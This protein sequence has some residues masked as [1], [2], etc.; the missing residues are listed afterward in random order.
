MGCHP[1]KAKA[2]AQLAALYAQ[3]PK[4]ALTM[5]IREQRAAA[6]IPNGMH[7]M[8]ISFPATTIRA[9]LVQRDGRDFYE[10]D[11]YA[12]VFNKPYTMYDMF[13]EYKEKVD[14]GA[15]TRSLS[16]SPD[17]AFLTN[18]RG[19]TMAR[20]TNKTL[21]L[22]KD[23]QGLAINALMNAGR[24]DVRDLASAIGDELITEMSIAFTI[25]DDGAR[26][27][28]DYTEL[29]LMELDIN[30]GDVSAVNYGANPYTSI[31]S[32]SSE[33]IRELRGLP[34]GALPDALTAISAAIGEAGD[35]LGRDALTRFHTAAQDVELGLMTR[36]IQMKRDGMTAEEISAAFPDLDF[37][38]WEVVDE[39]GEPGEEPEPA[40]EDRGYSVDLLARRL[41]DIDITGDS[42]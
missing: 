41:S 30:R 31:G 20:T 39:T 26:W 5:T 34:A 6:G 25:D 35:K 24:T 37:S 28:D 8:A 38:A 27:N 15:L 42:Q 19:L 36:A 23:M 2:N 14:P 12:T 29:T 3:E 18:H 16:N 33:I 11:G 22:T 9:K 40:V 17:V 4:A 10:V 21:S 1:T 32:R 13:G 7:R